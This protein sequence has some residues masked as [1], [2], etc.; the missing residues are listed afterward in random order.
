MALNFPA[1]PDNGDEYENYTY[2]ATRG[3]WVLNDTSGVPEQILLLEGSLQD[4]EDRVD[5]TESSISSIDSRVLSTEADIETL[6][7]SP[8]I[9]NSNTVSSNY[10]IPVGYNGVSAGPVTIAS[11]VTVTIPSGSSWSIV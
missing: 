2:D 7:T 9:L 4:L 5:V 6:Q 10:S 3:V 11:G 8:I 1:D